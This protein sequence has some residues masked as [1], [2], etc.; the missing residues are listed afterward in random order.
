LVDIAATG[1]GA[2]IQDIAFDAAGVLYGNDNE[3]L[4]TID[5]VTGVATATSAP[6]DVGGSSG[7][8]FPT[9]GVS[10]RMNA[11]AVDPTT[12]IL[13]G[14]SWDDS[15]LFTIDTS[16]GAATSLGTFGVGP[17]DMGTG[18]ESLIGANDLSGLAF[19]ST[20][21]LFMST[22]SQQGAIFALDITDLLAFTPLRI[23]RYHWHDEGYRSDHW[24]HID[25]SHDRGRRHRLRVW[26]GISASARAA[27]RPRCRW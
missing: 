1:F 24:R 15:E 7:S 23:R 25:G 9:D 17:V 8:M 6:F 16:T 12:N 27:S 4:W 14:A 13:Y 19:D 21:A 3:Q 5:L 22:G 11:L 2:A 10:I 20:G 18:L 26:L